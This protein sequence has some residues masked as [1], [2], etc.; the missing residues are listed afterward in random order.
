MSALRGRE[1]SC[2]KIFCGKQRGSNAKTYQLLIK[3]TKHDESAMI[4]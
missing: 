2:V 1:R 4:E 3:K